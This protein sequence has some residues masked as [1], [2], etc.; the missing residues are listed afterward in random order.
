MGYSVD[1]FDVFE[2]ADKIIDIV[3]N[4]V[5]FSKNA[6]KYSEL[7][8]WNKIVNDYKLVYGGSCDENT[9]SSK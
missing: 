1:C 6:L 9:I 2:I 5:E 7:F 4:Y 3:E 8:S